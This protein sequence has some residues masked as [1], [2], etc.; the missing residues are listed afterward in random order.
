MAAKSF[1]Q[2]ILMIIKVVSGIA[3]ES[4]NRQVYEI[5]R[6]SPMSVESLPLKKKG[7]KIKESLQKLLKTHIEKMSSFGSVQKLLK[8]KLVKDFLRLC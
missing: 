6:V 5:K 2:T 3:R 4:G 1:P 8:T 7:A